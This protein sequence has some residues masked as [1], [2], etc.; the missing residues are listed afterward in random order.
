MVRGA[1]HAYLPIRAG[2]GATRTTDFEPAREQLFVMV[3]T[4]RA[5]CRIGSVSLRVFGPDSGVVLQSSHLALM[6]E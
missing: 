3:Q 1:N 2:S 4:S 6:T 5:S